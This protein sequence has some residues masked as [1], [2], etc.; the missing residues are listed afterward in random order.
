MNKGSKCLL[1]TTLITLL[2]LT[3]MAQE[4][5]DREANQQNR[6]GQ[7]LQSGQITAGGAAHLENREA[8]INASRKADLAANG[9]HLTAAER[10]NLNRRENATSRQIYRDKHNA[11][12]QP[13]VA[14]R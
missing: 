8:R 9:G 12:T 3:S 2:P 1:A 4:V 5:R 7:G 11:I 14:P 6:I 13:G 10:R